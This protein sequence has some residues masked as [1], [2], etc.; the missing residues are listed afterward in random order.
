M[1]ARNGAHGIIHKA[2]AA[3]AAAA[4]ATGLLTAAG[5]ADTPVLIAIHIGMVQELG[6]LFHVSVSKLMATTIIGL[7]AGA[8]AGTA[9]AKWVASWIPIAGGVIC[10]GIA[11]THTEVLGWAAY[12]YFENQ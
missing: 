11:F 5:G 4:A 9:G 10:G 1:S 6:S 3:A 12:K 8:V 7:S 2:A